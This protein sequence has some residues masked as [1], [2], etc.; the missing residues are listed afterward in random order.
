[1]IEVPPLRDRVDD[2]PI[3]A[4]YFLRAYCEKYDKAS[5]ENQYSCS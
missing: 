3:L 2:I 1:M 5:N 4:N